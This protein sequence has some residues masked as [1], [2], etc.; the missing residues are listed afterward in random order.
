MD[1]CQVKVGFFVLRRCQA[2]AVA[3]CLACKRPT[4]A[5]HLI[6]ERKICTE[7]HSVT[8]EDDVTASYRDLLLVD[9]GVYS[10]RR[11]YYSIHSDLHNF[12]DME[13]LTAGEAFDSDDAVAFDTPS[14]ADE[15]H[16]DLGFEDS[17]D[18]F[19]S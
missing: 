14:D 5:Q 17:A 9:A 11:H 18:L 16:D 8:L 4:C 3:R 7:C 15:L 6:S 13:R 1:K 12:E 19:D 10:Y 2:K